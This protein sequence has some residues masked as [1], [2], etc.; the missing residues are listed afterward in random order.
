MDDFGVPPFSETTIYFCD[1]WAIVLENQLVLFCVL[2]PAICNCGLCGQIEQRLTR[3]ETSW[4]LS[5]LLGLLGTLGS[6]NQGWTN[7]NSLHSVDS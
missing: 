1:F 7:P 2:L 4:W 6:L 3:V 5:F